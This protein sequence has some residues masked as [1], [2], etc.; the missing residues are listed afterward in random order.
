MEVRINRKKYKCFAFDIETHNDDE[1][2]ALKETSMWLGCLID[3]T[4]TF[5]DENSY[6]YNMDQV[7]DKL[8]ELSTPKRVHGE[9]KKPCKNVCI[10][11]YNMSFEYSFLLPYMEERGFKYKEFIEKDDE[12][13]FNSITTHSVSSVWNVQLK[14]HKKS[15]IV[16]FRDLAKIY[17]GGLGK[18]AKAFGLPTQK[19]EID[20][21]LNRRHNYI[22]TKEEKIYCFKDTRIIIDILLEMQRRN[23]K[24]FFNSMSMASYSMRMMIKEGWPR[25]TKPYAKYRETY[26]ELE[27]AETNFL[28]KSVAGGITYAPERWQFK[29]IKE[30]I[31]HIDKNSMHPSSAYFNRF[32]YGKGE[33]HTGKPKR[34]SGYVNCCHVRV[35][36][37]DVKLH[38][39]ISLIGLKYIEKC[40]I[41]LWDFEIRTMY[42]CYVDLEVEYID[43]Y[44]YKTK[45]LPWRRYYANCY[46]ARLEAKAKGD[47]FNILYYKLLMNSSYGKALEK[48]HLENYVN[49]IDE[50]GIITSK[51]IPKDVKNQFNAKYTYLPYGSMIPAFSRCD[52]VELALKIG[53]EK[54]VYFDTDSIFFIADDESIANMNKYMPSQNFLGGWKVEETIERAMF[55]APKRYKAETDGKVYIKAGGINFTNY[56]QEKAKAEGLTELEDIKNYVDKYEFA[57]DEVNIVSSV[58]KVQRAYRV[59]GGTIIEFQDKEIKV[60]KKYLE[61]YNN[62]Q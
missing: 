42:K 5:D 58:W 32:A 12:F 23:D 20:Y 54:V 18:V 43:Y 56:I 15:G 40:E 17:G 21:R 22:P 46:N 49:M 10:Y 35:S 9:T 39:V 25:S 61:I 13:V 3:E 38:S 7:L 34:F 52:L 2:I 29:D 27:E 8:E 53:Y 36:F 41:T 28:R 48:P 47:T 11:C 45:P 19:G 26:P 6:Y 55:T 59:K 33:Y 24:F 4:H 57:F 50:E 30:K 1:S 62:N 51:T 44:E 37:S 14:F 31:I 16:M 60:P